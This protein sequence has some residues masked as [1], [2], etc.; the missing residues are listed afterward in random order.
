[1]NLEYVGDMPKVSAHG[2]GFDHT[3]PDK[4]TYLHAAVELLE[5]LSYGETETTKHLYKTDAKSMS[6]RELEQKLTK[7]V[8]DLDA[9]TL[10]CDKHS[11]ELV[12]ELV[13]R[14]QSNDS[15]SDDERTAWLGNI[16][17]M[18]EYY[19]QFV[20]NKT[21]YEAALDALADEIHVGKIKEVQVPM[22]RNYGMVLN[23]LQGVLE[24]CKSP[25][26]SKVEINSTKNGLL[27][28]VEFFH[29]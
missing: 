28:T 29:A 17:L 9:I 18:R 19:I 25:I 26:D 13:D 22:F 2:V 1:M 6:S 20:T 4:Y 5:A 12:S 15:L 10:R 27:A 7:Y 24:R 16:K 21:A 23:D 11:Q 8:K 3:Q 14:V